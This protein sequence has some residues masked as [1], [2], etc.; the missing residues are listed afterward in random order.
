MR[1]IDLLSLGTALVTV[2]FGGVPFELRGQEPAREI[3]LRLEQAEAQAIRGNGVLAAAEARARGASEQARAARAFRWPGV[4]ASAGFVRTDDPV[5]VFGTKLRQ[6]RFGEA[7]FAIPSLNAPSAVSDWTA[8]L[9]AVWGVADPARWAEGRAAEAGARA[10]DAQRARTAEGVV[11][12]TRL[13]YLGA[14]AARGAREALVAE[15]DA[16][17]E[18]EDRVTRRVAEGLA[19]DADRLRATAAVADAQARL[20]IAEAEYADAV[21]DLAVQLGW[22]ADSVPVP[23]PGLPTLADRSGAA[24]AGGDRADL[25]ASAAALDAARA[26]ADVFAAARL[27]SV[28]AFG[29]LGTHASGLTDDRAANWTV[30]VQV[31][32]P[33]FTGF[34][35]T[36]GRAAADEEARA[37]E[38]EHRDRLLR[39]GAEV[40]AARRGVEAAEGARAAARSA[41]DASQEAARLLALRYEEGMATLADLLRA[42]SQAAAFEA[43]LVEAEARWLMGL[44][45]LDFVLG[46]APGAAS[47]D[48]S[49]S[50]QGDDR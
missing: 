15:V 12:G 27:P 46:S 6:E 33:L 5:G 50:P 39:A 9:G 32:V 35:L 17:R 8:G 41:R 16:A 2:A 26:Q 36:A 29:H 40:S 43:R 21:G 7:D 49:D 18:T 3:E 31:S 22:G 30:G 24:P 42:Q 23:S 20:R 44:A 4:E 25:R 34:G 45:R 10:A 13:I 38:A 1:A 47:N 14:F 19:T 48:D 11:L 28:E 37:L